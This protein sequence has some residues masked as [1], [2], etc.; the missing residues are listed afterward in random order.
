VQKINKIYLVAF[1]LQRKKMFSVV[2]DFI[3]QI[4]FVELTFKL[5]KMPKNNN[6][7]TKTAYLRSQHSKHDLT[8][9][10]LLLT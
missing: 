8:D 10:S 5:T 6:N 2:I 3:P 4:L 9:H 7:N 1:F